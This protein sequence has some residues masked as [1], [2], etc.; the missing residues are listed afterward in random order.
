MGLDTEN[1]FPSNLLEH[2][3]EINR[4]ECPSKKTSNLREEKYSINMR[5][6]T[7]AKCIEKELRYY[8]AEV[9]NY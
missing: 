2:G 9:A 1:I 6:L 4:V 5:N 3:T 8:I 7:G